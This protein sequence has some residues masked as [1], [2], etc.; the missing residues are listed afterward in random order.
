MRALCAALLATLLSYDAF[1]SDQ[2]Y[3]PCQSCHGV[4]G[5]GNEALDAPNIAGLSAEYLA[6]QLRH[7][8]DGVR[9]V[10]LAD[11]PGRQMSLICALLQNDDDIRALAQ[12]VAD[13]PPEKPPTTLPPA[14]RYASELYQPCIIC[15]GANGEGVPAVGGP[16]L[17]WLD[18]W[19]VLR[20]LQYFKGGIRGAHRQDIGGLQMRAFA[21]ALGEGQM[22][23]LAAHVTTLSGEPGL[24]LTNQEAEQ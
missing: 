8:R 16:P 19:Y 7:F 20:Q 10:T 15:H 3:F 9:G 13:F 6:T 14:T 21:A 23:E 18:D 1:G 12:H 5:E 22:Q 2:L 4:Q 11:L 24:K 17:A